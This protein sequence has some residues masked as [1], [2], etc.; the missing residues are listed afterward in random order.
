MKKKIWIISIS[1]LIA[2]AVF[3]TTFSIRGNDAI[4]Y[5]NELLAKIVSFIFIDQFFLFGM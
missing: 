2:L 1:F 3:L 4:E 5:K